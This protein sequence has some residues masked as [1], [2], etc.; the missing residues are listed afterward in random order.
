MNE[1]RIA[2][3]GLAALFLAPLAYA[4]VTLYEQESTNRAAR[5]GA[6]WLRHVWQT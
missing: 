4:Q 2:I 3:F 5:S 6:P 1:F